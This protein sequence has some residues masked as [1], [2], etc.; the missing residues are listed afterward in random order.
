MINVLIISLSR[1]KD[2]QEIVQQIL[3]KFEY[4]DNVH[5]YPAFDGQNI[6]NKTLS[7]KI[8]APG[9]CYRKGDSMKSGELGCTLSHIGCISMAKSLGWEYVIILEDDI[10]L[11]DDFEKRIR[12]LLKNVPSDWEHIYLSG[13]PHLSESE[14]NN[15]ILNSFLNIIPSVWSDETPGYI[16]KNSAFDKMIKILSSL[17]TTTDDMINK[18]IFEYS[19][20]KS[21]MYFPFT[22]YVNIMVESQIASVIKTS[23]PSHLYFKNRLL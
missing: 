1:A 12:Y 7:I 3:N 14:K 16:I 11:C 23:H 8:D 15:P 5:V 19:N 4:R 21:Y 9:Y 13:V 20:L 18:S 17:E 22:L 10:T 6:M 2:R